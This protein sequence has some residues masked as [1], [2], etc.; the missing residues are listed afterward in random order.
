MLSLNVKVLSEKGLRNTVT[1][2]KKPVFEYFL[3]FRFL[4]RAT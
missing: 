4:S 2:Q 3:V 1:C